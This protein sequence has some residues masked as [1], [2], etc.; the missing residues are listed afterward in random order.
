MEEEEEGDGARGEARGGRGKGEVRKKKGGKRWKER[1][2]E[3]KEEAEEEN[4]NRKLWVN[5]KGERGRREGA[6]TGGGRKE[7]DK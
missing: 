4:G 1:S 6:G 5:D 3:K 7:R 2:G